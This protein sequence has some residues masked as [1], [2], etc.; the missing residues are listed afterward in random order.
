MLRKDL[1]GSGDK[2]ILYTLP[3]LIIGLIL[4]KGFP[5]L[6]DTLNLSLL[7]KYF[8]IFVLGVGVTIWLW[9]VYLVTTVASKDKL[10]TVG[11][12]TLV[13]HPIY[14]SVAL[15]VIP[16]IGFLLNSWLGLL[17][18]IAMY[19]NSIK[20]SP[21]EEKILSKKFGSSW[22]KYKDSVKIPWL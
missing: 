17:I 4:N 11:P 9:S 12:Y 20:Y 15:L 5:G 8:F 22:K 10:M 3:Y 16:C 19:L 14:T 1:I 6:F 18:G 21:N 13:K 2:I 7:F